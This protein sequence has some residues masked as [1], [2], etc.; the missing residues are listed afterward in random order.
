MNLAGAPDRARG[1]SA[2]SSKA[3]ARLYNDVEA[4]L[5]LGNYT[6]E[7]SEAGES[8]LSILEER[9]PGVRSSARE[10]TDPPALSRGGKRELDRDASMPGAAYPVVRPPADDEDDE[11]GTGGG[12]GQTAR[13]PRRRPSTR[14]ASRRSASSGGV[15]RSSSGGRDIVE[16]AAG[17]SG[18]DVADAVIGGLRF[19][20]VAGVVYQVLQPKGSTAF[21]GVLGMV[22]N[23][24]RDLVAPIDPLARVG[25]GV[26]Q[27]QGRTQ[28]QTPSG[29][30]F[31]DTFDTATGPAPF[32]PPTN[33]PG[34]AGVG[35]FDTPGGT[36]PFKPPSNLPGAILVN[37]AR[38]TAPTW[39]TNFNVQLPSIF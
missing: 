15:R 25:A 22:G 16:R 10:V 6:E 19:L 29:A 8:A 39:P 2:G 18:D 12:G 3:A 23:A 30:V 26:P 32:A 4:E 24:V 13:P 11:D 37:P 14:D 34:S 31:S 21:S 28:Y 27:G 9:F 5:S 36:A 7:D 33:L 17:F 20:L 1:L 35:E 38:V